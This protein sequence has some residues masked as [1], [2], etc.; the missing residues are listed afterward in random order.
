MTLES[1]G[2][3][4]WRGLEEL[5]Q[6]EGF[7]QMLAAEFPEQAA[8]WTDPI[9]RRRFL[10]LMGASLALAGLG[11][12]STQ[13]A[14][15][16]KVLPYVRQ[17]EEVVPGKPLY[18]ATAMPQAG[19]ALGVLVESHEGR[20]T[21][22]EG[23]PSHPAS[24]N[25]KDP[26][27]G[28]A[29][30]V[31]SQ[32]SVLG[33]YDP[34]RSQAV[35]YR[36]Q[37]RSW[38]EALTAL[39]GAADKLRRRGGGGLRILTGTVTSPTLAA[40]LREVLGE[41]GFPQAKWVQYEPAGHD[42]ARE[43]ARLAFGE[44]VNTY[45]DLSKADVILALDADFLHCG[46]VGVRYT[47]DFSERRR[48]RT[49]GPKATP[50]DKAT[51][52]RLYA[53]ESML[54]NTGAAADHRLALRA[55]QVEHFARA[56]AKEL[57][58]AEA[59]A[60]GELPKLARDW[61]APLVKDLRSAR[62]R[63]VVI[64]GDGQPARVHALVH[65]INEKLG[66]VGATILHTEPVEAAPGDQVAVLRQLVADMRGKQVEMLLIL[67]ANPVY[68]APADLDFARHLAGVPL[69]FHLGLYQD[70]T[71][72]ACDWHIPET[73]YLEAWSDARTFDGTASILQPLVEPIFGGRSAHEFLAA[74]SDSPDRHGREIVRD[75]WRA[76]WQREANSGSFESFWEKAVQDGVVAGSEFTRRP[77][78][79]RPGW[80]ER[81]ADKAP[82]PAAQGPVQEIVFRPDPTLFD[83]RYA[84]NGWLQELPKPVTRLT[85]DNAA[86]MSPKTARDLGLPP[87][88]FGVHGGERGETYVEVVE[89]TLPGRPPV[90][91]PALA[92]PGHADGSVT[93][94]LGHGRTH[95][96]RVGNGTGFNAYLL[97]TADAPW[98]D[99][100]PGLSL[101]N[102]GERYTL[103]C[104]QMHHR[105]EGRRPV[106][107]GILAD[108]KS[109]PGYAEQVTSTEEHA[110]AEP[111][112]PP[113][114]E[115][116]AEPKKTDRRLVPLSLY[117]ANRAE[118]PYKGHKWGMV[119][120]LSACTG[121]S[122]C[123]VA[124]QSENNIPVVGKT[125]V[126]RGREMHWLRIDRYFEGKPDDASS[127]RTHF[128]PVPCMHCEKAPCELVCPV[129]ATVHSHDGLNDMVYNRC[130]G[131]RYCSNN[132]PYKVR[133]FNFLQYAD[134]NTP[135]LKMHRNPE[136][137]VRS[138]GVMEKCTY[139]V[140][141]IRTAEV[142]EEKQLVPLLAEVVRKKR[143]GEITDEQAA[144]QEREL[145]HRHR[146]TSADLMTA[147][148]AACPAGAIVFG[149]L[150]DQTSAV[151]H[152]RDEPLNY[153]LLAELN[154]QPRTTY[155]A[156]LR[157]P[158]P[159]MP[160]S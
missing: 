101:R 22:V 139:C 144:Q 129:N 86:L 133:R 159:E 136:V 64:A 77:R 135:S 58:V 95:A 14:P 67:G 66:N 59:P 11:G 62:G 126:T 19:D 116:P 108:Y 17:P 33:L 52:S 142:E 158:N 121:C 40:Q 3:R 63:C 79:V 141:R 109:K 20:P 65:A 1:A 8:E 104:V 152:W 15:R 85:W 160:R 37:P 93:L 94:Y 100:S 26:A 31:F 38:G 10:T 105:M 41:S 119:I 118:F 18:F 125:E 130:V 107:D 84:N 25:P 157:N 138:R 145:R 34:D 74:L 28:G 39:R 98:I 48:V 13:P 102:T 9:S 57:G 4:Y 73:H 23:N 24:G 6:S 46:A 149:D 72:V 55:A 114:G 12:C 120:D 44:Y 143:R 54:T 110:P 43:G 132:C 61:L 5:L 50:L 90:R 115:H 80:A 134:F 151:K 83:G 111:L 82:K 35:T 153:G 60:A 30:D 97:R 147:C 140:Q 123:V 112:Q 96:G 7:R 78:Q 71:A 128:Q 154:T 27:S 127:L 124:C 51:M 56:L 99:E 89:I 81:G 42:G 131:T 87:I 122:A 76:W 106:R 68:T 148:Q 53:V 91:A 45:Y 75:Y 16:D 137:T 88:Q 155:L 69:R 29:T 150:N 70:E 103:A 146:I 21:K 32:A 92:V 47:R 113:G 2:P 117:E 49:V 156:S 36:G